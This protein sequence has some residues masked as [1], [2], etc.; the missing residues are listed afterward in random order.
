MVGVVGIRAMCH[1]NP[2]RRIH[3]KFDLAYIGEER[4]KG[5]G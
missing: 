1:K 4:G 5:L 2:P 3:M